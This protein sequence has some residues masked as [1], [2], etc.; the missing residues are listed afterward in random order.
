[1]QLSEACGDGSQ[2]HNLAVLRT[3]IIIC[4]AIR[5]LLRGAD[6][7]RRVFRGSLARPRTINHKTKID[8][9][10]PGLLVAKKDVIKSCSS[11]LL[12]PEWGILS[13]EFAIPQFWF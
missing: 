11:S 5:S 9:D 13:A 12:Q 6:L 2:P 10:R 8:Q 1:M 4:K 3:A 7:S